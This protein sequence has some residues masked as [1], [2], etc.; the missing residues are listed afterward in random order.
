MRAWVRVVAVAIVVPLS[1]GAAWPQADAGAGAPAVSEVDAA[2]A[3]P[4]P[5]AKVPEADAAAAPE[6]ALLD[7]DTLDDLVAPVALYPDALLAQVLVAATYPLDVMKADRFLAD[8]PDLA[9]KE[10][11]DKAAAQGWDA[12]V[13]VLAGGFPDVIHRLADD[14]DWTQDLGDAMLAQT[15]D[16]FDAV[17]RMRAQ[18]MAAGNLASNA[19]QTV[20][21]EGDSI[22]IE[23]AD[24]QVVYVPTYDPEAAYVAP[25]AAAPAATE[26]VATQPVVT[27]PVTTTD[28]FTT[29]DLI[30]TGV[31]AF[32][33]AMLVDAIFDDDDDWDDYWRGPPPIHWDDDDFRPRPD[34]D[35]NGDVNI[36]RSRDR[37][38]VRIGDR[39]GT[40][41]GW[42]PTADQRAAA[43]DRL[44][45]R[46]AAGTG[47]ARPAGGL[48]Q[49][50]RDKIRAH[51]DASDVQRKLQ[52]KAP[53]AGGRTAQPPTKRPAGS[54]LA[55]G[56]GDRVETDRTAARGSTSLKRD[57]KPAAAKQR[58]STAAHAK[59]VSRPSANRT[60]PRAAPEKASVLKKQ[61]GGQRARAAS[62][63]GHA[64]RRH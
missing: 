49:A 48:D 18:A 42:E 3:V 44:A 56:R 30:T 31:V 21:A 19:A 62:A 6:T 26:P 15:D 32:G 59:Q 10:R 63:R 43:Q 5:A 12:S 35:V 60:P 46:Q 45:A 8:N 33:S 53:A 13:A 57:Q 7:D 11:S 17:Q 51:G 25:P 64:G 28:G 34:I 9:D 55:P 29:G 37:N 47:R 38:R 50:Q 24:P 1:A 54:A 52:A 4:R 41:G 58:A 2:G 16:V 36:D 61:G 27:Q 20:D 23:P 14:I 40:G 39:P 22:S